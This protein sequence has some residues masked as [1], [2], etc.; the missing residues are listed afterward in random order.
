M[1][2]TIEQAL[3]RGVALHN[4]GKLEEAEHLYRAV[5]QTQPGQPDANHNLG[6]IALS[7]NK[8]DEALPLFKMA[9]EANP[10]IE[11]YWLSYI[12]ALIHEKYFY[13]AKQAIQKAKKMGFTNQKIGA[14]EQRLNENNLTPSERDSSGFFNDQLNAFNAIEFT[15]DEKILNDIKKIASAPLQRDDFF[16]TA[17]K[18]NS[19]IK[20]ES[21]CSFKSFKLFNDLFKKLIASKGLQMAASHIDFNERIIMYSGFIVIRSRC[22]A[23]S[24]HDDWFPEC[25]TNAFTLLTP[26][27]HPSDGPNLLF[28]DSDG[29]DRKYKYEPGKGI[30]FSNKFIHSTDVGVSSSPSFLLSM[31]F[32]TDRMKYWEAISETAANQGKVYRLP[33]GHFVYNNFD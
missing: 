21:A 14:L 7:V 15:F 32:G 9:V 25:G 29:V 10:S 24:F 26:I 5:L 19:D 6:L 33:S 13:G 17:P 22:T 11:Q 4:Q 12:D 30:V 1:E 3:Q 18:W 2:L 23:P 28:K 31:V 8:A 27:I 16:M 20:W